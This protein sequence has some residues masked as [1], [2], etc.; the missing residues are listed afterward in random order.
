MRRSLAITAAFLTIG[1]TTWKKVSLVENAEP[2]NRPEKIEI[3]ST[4]GERLLYRPIVEGDSL[5]GWLDKAQTNPEAFA[6]SDIR[7]ARVAHFSSGRTAL[8]IGGGLVGALAIW[9]LLL[10]GSEGIAPSY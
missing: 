10:V 9:A 1:C 8:A 4:K 5:R 3:L 6:L 7:R 2:S